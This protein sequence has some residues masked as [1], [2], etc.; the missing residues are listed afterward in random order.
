MAA[1]RTRRG[2]T[3]IELLVVIAIIAI[4]I[5]L[6]LPA[7]QQAREAARRSQC[8]NNL[9]QLG[10]A[11]HSYHDSGKQFPKV[12]YSV[13][14][15]ISPNNQTGAVG[16]SYHWE[17]RSAQTMLLP[18][19]DQT[20]LY[21]KINPNAWW[22]SQLVVNGSSNDVLRQT[23]LPTLICPSDTLYTSADKGNCSYLIST[24]PNNGW[25]ASSTS[26]VG[27][28]HLNFPTSTADIRD[29]TSNTIAFA[30][31][32][33]GDNNNAVFNIS[34]LVR[35]Q[36]FPGGWPTTFAT[37][38]LLNTYGAQCAAPGAISNHHSH[39]GRDWA[40]P[41]MWATAF[42]T[43]APPNWRYPNCYTCGGCGWGDGAGVFPSRA[44]HS[45]GTHHLF[46]DGATRFVNNT[47]NVGVY[48]ALGS[49]ASKDVAILP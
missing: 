42:N 45:G 12:C 6:L 3:L 23:L 36:P 21:K 16:T 43:L 33:I 1:S 15:T 40:S 24:G 27:F 14:D 7:V 10:V 8:K 31:G 32:L 48:Q 18:Y 46:G 11:L 26:N 37:E 13:S 2:F 44:Q 28:A 5:A 34:D 30:E 17:G 22:A 20:P 19:M 35:N 38:A 29:G 41:M 39:S 47:I 25:D 49:K 9:K 4:L